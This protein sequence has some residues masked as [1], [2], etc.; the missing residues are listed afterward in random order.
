MKP[1]KASLIERLD[2]A[3]DE[4]LTAHYSKQGKKGGASTSKAKQKASRENG[5]QGGR[6][7][8]KK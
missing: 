4:A 6:P 5:K 3:I 2:L 1:T 7:R 8:G